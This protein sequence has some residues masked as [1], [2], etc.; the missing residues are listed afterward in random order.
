MSRRATFVVAIAL[1]L[2]V[3]LVAGCKEEETKP[4]P[5]S[6][7]AAGPPNNVAGS[8]NDPAEGGL[9]LVDADLDGGDG[10]VCSTFTLDGNTV[11]QAGVIG[12]PPTAVGG[13]VTD[14]TYVLTDDSVFV[15]TSGIAGPTGI[16]AKRTIVIATGKLDDAQDLGGTGKT[17]TS[18]RTTSAYSATGSTIA[19]T[20]I[21]PSGGGGAQYQFTTTDTTLVLIDGTA[22]EAFTFTKR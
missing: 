7:G 21:C 10:A 15:G 13:T 19:L 14:G 11:E 2:P 6:V 8:N 18:S 9:S 4:G 1:L 22:K 3:A 16:T 20:A 12:D 17:V 5:A